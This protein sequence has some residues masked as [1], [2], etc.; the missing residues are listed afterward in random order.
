MVT[1]LPRAPVEVALQV[2]QG[3]LLHQ[4]VIPQ[5]LLDVLQVHA[6]RGQRVLL[7]DPVAVGLEVAPTKGTQRKLR[8]VLLP[9][10]RGRSAFCLA[11]CHRG[12]LLGRNVPSS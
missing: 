12:P 10:Q 6:D 4:E 11:H 9:V 5:G 1:L 7:H 3:E 2:L 8:G